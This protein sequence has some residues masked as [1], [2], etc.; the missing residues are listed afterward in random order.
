VS[1]LDVKM[2]RHVQLT[3]FDIKTINGLVQR[4][5]ET[6]WFPHS[7]PE[8]V[9]AAVES[10]IGRGLVQ[11]IEREPHGL[12][13]RLTDLGRLAASQ[14]ETMSVSTPSVDVQMRH[15]TH[16]VPEPS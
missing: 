1:G 16:E 3:V 2:L 12:F 5:G 13:V 14:I 7:K 6:A 11:I 9:L 15:E 10:M 8:W 4:G